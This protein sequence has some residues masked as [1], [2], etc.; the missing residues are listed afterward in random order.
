MK[1][2][3]PGPIDCVLDI[4]PPFAPV[5]AVRAA[6]MTVRPYGRVALMGG[7]GLP[8]GAGLELP[9]PWIMRNCITIY[10]VWMYPPDAT[11]R[12]IRLIRIGPLEAATLNP[13]LCLFGRRTNAPSP[14]LD[15][16][17]NFF[18]ATSENRC[19]LIIVSP[20]DGL[21]FHDCPSSNFLSCA[22]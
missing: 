15:P 20:L 5:T 22:W 10:G 17:S 2:A 8:A 1:R 19:L 13:K 6:L 7:V 4:L 11:I 3:A 14:T 16:L 9:D 18:C 21:R 12:L